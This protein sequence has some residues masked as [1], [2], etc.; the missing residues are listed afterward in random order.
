MERS[1]SK[2]IGTAVFNDSTRPITSVKDLIIDPE[3]GKIL[4]FVV[5]I[6]KKMI[7]TPMDILSWQENIKVHNGEAVI[8]A[9][10]VL[11]VE[12]VLNN[13]INIL[14]NKVYTK[15]GE[16]LG[17]VIDYTVDNQSYLLKNLFVSKGFL[18]LI[19]Y[20]SRIIPYKNIIEIKREKIVAKDSLKKIDI[21]QEEK[22]VRLEDAVA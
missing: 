4:A 3:T 21:K 5:N 19:R 7:V 15:N 20:Q 10:E 8:N 1:Y 11:R 16:Y 6:N 9:N 13:Q 22:I 12:N 17:K 18:G 14:K 2:I